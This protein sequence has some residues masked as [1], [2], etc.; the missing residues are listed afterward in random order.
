M[1][2][3]SIGT[4]SSTGAS[5]G[6]G[7]RGQRGP[8]TFAHDS[9]S[10]KWLRL[11]V[12]TSRDLRNLSVCCGHLLLANYLWLVVIMIAHPERDCRLRMTLR[13]FADKSS[14]TYAFIRSTA[15][16]IATFT[17]STVFFVWHWG[18]WWPHIILANCPLLFH[19]ANRLDSHVRSTFRR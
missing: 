12:K 16:A 3:Y 5:W 13:G 19:L 10:H 4:F 6:M 11:K 7:L 8:A 14:C 17:T 2:S 1:L 18:H 9:C 15:G